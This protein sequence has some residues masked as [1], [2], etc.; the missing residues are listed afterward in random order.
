MSLPRTSW[1]LQLSLLQ[2]FKLMAELMLYVC[3]SSIHALMIILQT[4]LE[5]CGV[6]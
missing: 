6:G 2:P 3:E 5:G 1:A 4:V